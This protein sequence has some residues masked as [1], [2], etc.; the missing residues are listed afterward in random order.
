MM[1]LFLLNWKWWL[2]FLLSVYKCDSV[3]VLLGNVR[4]DCMIRGHDMDD[5]MMIIS[6]FTRRLEWKKLIHLLLMLFIVSL[7][8]L[9]NLIV[10]T[11]R[12]TWCSQN[13]HHLIV[14][15][16]DGSHFPVYQACCMHLYCIEQFYVVYWIP[17]WGISSRNLNQSIKE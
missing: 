1:I 5:E 12:K 8:L 7:M 6:F 2:I 17:C 11:K 13:H 14:G 10:C 15:K 4:R 16:T 9:W 3:Y